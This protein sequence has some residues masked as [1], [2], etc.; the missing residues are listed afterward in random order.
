VKNHRFSTEHTEWE[1]SDRHEGK[2]AW[3]CMIQGIL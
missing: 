2:T 3:H 1:V